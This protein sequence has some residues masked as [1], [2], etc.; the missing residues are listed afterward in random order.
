MS[1]LLSELLDAFSCTI[2]GNASKITVTRI[3]YDSRKAVDA[4]TLFFCMPGARL[5][6]HDYAAK[7]YEAGCRAFVVEHTVDLPEDAVQIVVKTARES[8]ALLSAKF[9]GNPADKLKLIGI[10]GTKGKTTTAIL[11][12]E[13]LSCC[14][15][16]CAYIGSN[17]I[18]I[19]DKHYPTVNTT[20]ESREL[21]RY[22]A[23]MLEDGVTHVA[24]EVSS[25]ALNNYRVMG[26][27][28]DSAIY[29]N[30]APDHISP[31]EHPTFEDYRDAKRKL[32]TDHGVGT[33]IYNAD[34]KHA[35]Y[36][37]HG[38]NANLV[39][40]AIHADAA[41]K[42]EDIRPYRDRTS[43][44]IDFDLLHEGVK[45]GFRMRTPGEFSVYNGLSAIAVCAH[46]GVSLREISDALRTISIKGRFEIVDALDGVTFIIDYA[47][48]GLSL[49]HALEVLRTYDPKRLICVFGCIGGRTFG[50]RKE[51]AETAGRLADFT[52]ITSDN[53]DNEDPDVIIADVLTYFDKSKLY[54]T[55]TD[56]EE[57]VRFVTRIADEGD[58]IL[59]AG[60]GHEDYQL[61]NGEKVPFSEKAILLD[62]AAKIAADVR[63]AVL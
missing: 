50:R 24:M 3:E 48:N 25:Q 61:V 7:V 11:V 35:E 57:A 42:A 63:A 28:F 60:K 51:L 20:P 58:I 37:I 29:T 39:S 49:T 14:G 47:H 44:G 30:L 23:L 6:G 56:R 10:T 5:D 15:I 17:G 1:I 21:H 13:I 53:P 59:F 45:T 26:L 31:E 43:L 54:T 9:Y 12:S 55:I 36:M 40:C 16:K 41:F 8:L 62:E 19:G 38:I 4:G 18:Q 52:V 46:Y 33:I 22:F 27:H 2:H 34:D 32:F